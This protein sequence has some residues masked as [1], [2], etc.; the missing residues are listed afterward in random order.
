[1]GV[2]KGHVALSILRNGH[3][4]LSIL[5]VYG[6]RLFFYFPEAQQEAMSFF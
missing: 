1:M 6:H 4:A 3:V 5:E 2:T